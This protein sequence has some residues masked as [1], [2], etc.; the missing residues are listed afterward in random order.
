MAMVSRGEIVLSE[1]IKAEVVGIDAILN[2]IGLRA[3]LDPDDW[4]AERQLAQLRRYFNPL[5]PCA[6]A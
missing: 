5:R 3:I 4:P 6:A 1:D 2:G